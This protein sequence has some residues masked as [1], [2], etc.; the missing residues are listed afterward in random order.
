MIALTERMKM[1]NAHCC[2][3]YVGYKV[4]TWDEVEWDENIKTETEVVKDDFSRCLD[5]SPYIVG[6]ER[7]SVIM[8][9]IE[10][11]CPDRWTVAEVL[12]VNQSGA[13]RGDDVPM[14]REYIEVVKTMNA[15][16]TM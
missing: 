13:F 9:L 6:S 4:T 8:A 1:L 10:A 12:G 15:K 5:I 7:N 3:E 16:R 11:G 2:G 14:I